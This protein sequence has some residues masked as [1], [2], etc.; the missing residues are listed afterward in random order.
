MNTK[1]NQ[2]IIN[3]VDDEDR[4]RWERLQE[5]MRRAKDFS[6]QYAA[7]DKVGE[8]IQELIN[9]IESDNAKQ[10]NHSRVNIWL[11]GFVVVVILFVLVRIF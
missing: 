7:F 1:D 4:K 9:D 10:V 5:S 11:V 2:T 6:T 3:I 8:G